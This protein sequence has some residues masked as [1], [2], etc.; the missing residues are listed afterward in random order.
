M[1]AARSRLRLAP[2]QIELLESRLAPA[3]LATP[4]ALVH[5]P[6]F[7]AVALDARLTVAGSA[8]I[9]TTEVDYYRFTAPRTGSYRFSALTPTS[10][11]DPVLGVFRANGTRLAFSDNRTADDP[12]AET[13]VLLTAGQRYFLGVTNRVGSPG[14]AYR[15]AIQ[16]PGPADD[17]FEDNDTV[18]RAT[19]LGTLETPF[20]LS[21]LIL[22]DTTDWFRFS[23]NGPGLSSNHVSLAFNHSLGDL[24]LRLYDA[25]GNL[26][27]FSTSSSD[28]ER[29]GL[30]GLPAGSYLVQVYGYKGATNPA[31]TLAIDPGQVI[32]APPVHRVLYLNF[33][34]AS[35]THQELER[36]AGTDWPAFVERIDADED[37]VEVSPFLA[38][39]TD[40]EQIIARILELVQEDL[41]PFHLEVQRWTG[42]AVEGVGATTIFLGKASLTG[43][44]THISSDVDIGNDNAVDLSFVNNEDWGSVE[45]TA[46]AMADVSLHEAGHT[47]GLW[48]VNSGT[49]LE[50]MG[51][52]YNTPTSQWTSNT[53]FLDRTFVPFVGT[54]GQ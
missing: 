42:K 28:E 10:T 6:S 16:G 27:R 15:W 7:R 24:D 41:Q 12:D 51:V 21:R 4:P 52:R 38:S 30:Q 31:Y 32:P 34:G 25:A 39:H 11:L 8:A 17:A 43:V 5:V 54:N 50:T 36:Y 37:G 26:L 13:T 14:G 18:A 45:R 46:L 35:L 53:S 3:W 23:M 48:H 49:A 1:S 19:P 2:L 20:Q 47:W 22:R 29:I 44:T 40:R 33:D 9:A